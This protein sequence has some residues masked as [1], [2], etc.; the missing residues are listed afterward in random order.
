MESLPTLW[1]LFLL[2]DPHGRLQDLQI[3]SSFPIIYF[4]RIPLYKIGV[5]NAPV[6]GDPVQTSSR[7]EGSKISLFSSFRDFKVKLNSLK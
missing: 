1:T 5:V 2:A 6:I 3:S 4:R 7:P